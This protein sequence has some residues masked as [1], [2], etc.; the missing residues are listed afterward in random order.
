MA[1][2]ATFRFPDMNYRSPPALAYQVWFGGGQVALYSASKCQLDHT[3]GLNE[4]VFASLQSL[5]LDKL[6]SCLSTCGLPILG[7]HCLPAQ[8]RIYWSTCSAFHGVAGRRVLVG[9][10]AGS[11]PLEHGEPRR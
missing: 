6:F 3:H 11:R 4:L 5:Q 9:S 8:G 10:Q 7:H 2:A 1:D